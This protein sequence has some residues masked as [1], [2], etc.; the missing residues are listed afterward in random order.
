[1]KWLWDNIMTRKE[2]IKR[3]LSFQPTP[4]IPYNLDF[5]R[6]A[7]EK[8]KVHYQTDDID[9]AIGNYFL[10]INVSSNAGAEVNRVAAGLMEPLE[11]NR[12]R[13]EFGVVWD[14]RAGDDIGV[15]ENKIIPR[16]DLAHLTSPDP[17]DPHR[18]TGFQSVVATKGDRYV[19]AVF[20]SPLFQRCWF[21]CGMSEFLMYLAAEPEFVESL[22]DR[23]M[24]FSI[25]IAKECARLGADGLMFYDDYGQQSGTLF[26][27]TMFRRFFK[28]RLSEMF[29]AARAEGLDVFLHSCGDV[30]SILKDIHE[31]GAQVFN[32]FQP[33]VMDARAI[34]EQFRGRLAFYGGVSTQRT[35]PFGTPDDVRREVR[36]RIA[37]FQDHGGY[38]LAPAHAIQ[39][40]VPLNNILAFLDAAQG[41]VE[42]T[43]NTL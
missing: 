37:L 15:P 40:D 27:P 33:E 20:S 34:A 29:A 32:P 18:W 17:L 30:Q 1:M 4:A 12:F 41:T 26:S 39:H 6:A 31:A 10:Q 28:P 7:R 38:I 11:R 14:K 35:L 23:L 9:E 21:L 25:A 43:T 16:P 22:L 3:A 8:L 19:Q 36:D 5:T 2:I 13:D 24:A 42:R